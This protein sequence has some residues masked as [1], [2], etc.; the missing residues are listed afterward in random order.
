V[1]SAGKRALGRRPGAALISSLL[2]LPAIL[3]L[4]GAAARTEAAQIEGV[5]FSERLSLEG[6]DLALQGLALLRYRI[7]FKG[8]VAALY[9][10]PGVRKDQVL[11]DV[12]RRL[13]IEYF[14]SIPA[15]GFA[16]ATLEGIEKNVEP[17]TFW[18][19]RPEIERF[20][21]FYAD[22]KAGDRYQLTYLPGR[23]TELALNGEGRGVVEGA[24]FAAALFSIWLGDEPFDP[25]LKRQLLEDLPPGGA[26]E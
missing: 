13:E 7:F 1:G 14:W 16:E 21:R 12:P 20:N 10:A 17:E 4:S 15:S 25:S 11:A 8:Y 9:L 24:A 22:V 3:A 6:T 19:L 5:H 18:T 26:G 23:G 2:T